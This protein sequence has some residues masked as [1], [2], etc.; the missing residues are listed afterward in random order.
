MTTG[1]HRGQLFEHVTEREHCT[2]D[3]R[4]VT[5]VELWSR[6]PDCG[7]GFYQLRT[8]SAWRNRRR[9]KRRCDA[10]G[11]LNVGRKVGRVQ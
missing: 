3:G 7:E 10:C 9:I 11:P 5:L 8:P 4:W 2:R 6:C 1:R